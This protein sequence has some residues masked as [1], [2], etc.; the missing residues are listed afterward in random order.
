M[1]LQI[2]FKHL[3]RSVCN[4]SD[5]N[6]NIIMYD[7][8][9]QFKLRNLQVSFEYFLLFYLYLKSIAYNNNLVKL[10]QTTTFMVINKFNYLV[11]YNPLKR[12]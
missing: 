12:N 5:K 8:I 11:N 6:N 2:N 3:N 1:Q 4:S 7:V 10:F 9:T